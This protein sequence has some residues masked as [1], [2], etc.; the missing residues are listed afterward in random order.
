MQTI[1]VQSQGLTITSMSET[2]QP[3]RQVASHELLGGRASRISFTYIGR[4]HTRRRINRL[5]GQI[6]SDGQV[7]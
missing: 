4:F 5:D 6:V 1:S 3:I 2:A 7:V